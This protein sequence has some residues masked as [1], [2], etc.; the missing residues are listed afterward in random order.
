MIEVRGGILD[1]C[2][3]DVTMQFKDG[4][5][6][7]YCKKA[8]LRVTEDNNQHMVITLMRTRARVVKGGGGKWDVKYMR[9]FHILALVPRFM[10]M[11]N[12]YGTQFL[13]FFE[14]GRIAGA[15]A[16]PKPLGRFTP[17][18]IV[19]YINR[20]F[21]VPYFVIKRLGIE[22]T[23]FSAIHEIDMERLGRDVRR[24]I[25]EQLKGL[26]VLPKQG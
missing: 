3:E 17:T 19:N 25:E 11:L 12:S 8:Y 6:V 16:P 2:I 7:K 24:E 14:D 23:L 9:D 20:Y 1:E 13:I 15:W 4:S 21:P 22:K 10:G 26:G 18:T 5:K